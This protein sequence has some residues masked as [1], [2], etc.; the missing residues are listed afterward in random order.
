MTQPFEF[1][2]VSPETKAF[3]E[4]IPDDL[5]SEIIQIG[6]DWRRDKFRIAYVTLE[7]VEI[8]KAGNF[9]KFQKYKTLYQEGQRPPVSVMAVYDGI[10]VLLSR[11][12][13]P[14]TVRYW[15]GVLKHFP[16]E[17]VSNYDVLSFDH[18]AVASQAVDPTAALDLCLA[19]TV[20]N[21]GIP[22][23]ADWLEDTLI[24]Q[25]GIQVP[26]PPDNFDTLSPEAQADRIVESNA[27]SAEGFEPDRSRILETIRHAGEVF[28]SLIRVAQ[29]GYDALQRNKVDPTDQ[30]FEELLKDLEAVVNKIRDYI[31]E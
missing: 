28:L 6:T 3:L 13:S 1:S 26:Q 19:Q 7:L 4:L 2:N 16:S 20:A 5:Q 23:T 10:S 27:D 29:R 17:I 31:N 15:A 14:R 18:F 11:E 21:S 9:S 30:T 8:V 24:R 22:P 25:G 12:A